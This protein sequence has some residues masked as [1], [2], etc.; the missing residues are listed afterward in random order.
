MKM[1]E[2]KQKSKAL[3]VKPNKMKKVELIH[4]IQRS[5]GYIE[6]YG[7]SNGNCSQVECCFREDCLKVNV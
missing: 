4:A 5:E 7:K 3:G 1:T 2:L 6:C